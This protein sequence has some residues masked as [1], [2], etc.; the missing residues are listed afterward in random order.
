M[1]RSLSYIKHRRPKA[2]GKWKGSYIKDGIHKELH[3]A[4]MAA[5]KIGLSLLVGQL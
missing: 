5:H 4:I 2:D 3:S 1:L